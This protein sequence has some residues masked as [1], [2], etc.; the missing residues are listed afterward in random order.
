MTIISHRGYWIKA[1][2]KNTSLAFT[3]SFQMGFG[4]E[5]DV[6]D[7]NGAIV[8]AHDIPSPENIPLASFLELYATS[9]LPLALNIKADGLQQILKQFI[10]RY[11]VTNYFVFDMSIPDMLLYLKM[12]M[13]VFFRQSEFEPITE[14]YHDCKGVWLDAFKSTWYDENVISQHLMNKKQVAIVSDE[15]HKRDFS[16]QWKMLKE[17]DCIQNEHLILSTDFPEKAAEYF[18]L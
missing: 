11:Q 3:R 1:E 13:P 7:H 12:G 8:I 4:T 6:R 10:D 14:L 17:M 18:T 2:E 5:T 9:G 16:A 15:L